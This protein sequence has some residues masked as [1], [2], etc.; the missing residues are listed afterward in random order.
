MTYSEK[1]RD[2][3]WQKKRLEILKRDNFTCQK[4]C[5]DEFELHV[6]HSY[7]RKGK[8]P[9]EY[10]NDSLLTVCKYCHS[11]IE[12]LKVFLSPVLNLELKEIYKESKG[13]CENGK[14]LIALIG[15]P[16]NSKLVYL[17]YRPTEDG[18]EPVIMINEHQLQIMQYM[19][20]RYSVPKP[21]EVLWLGTGQ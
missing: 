10:E 16:N 12:H 18:V 6:H 4:C 7:Y 8:N 13:K 14:Y 3:R 21:K 9:W 20:N 5:D 11:I 19:S 17:F 15:Y 1:L 2:P